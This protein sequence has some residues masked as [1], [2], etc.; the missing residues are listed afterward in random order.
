[1][2]Q[3]AAL[4]KR[5]ADSSQRLSHASAKNAKYL[6]K[7]RNRMKEAKMKNAGGAP[8]GGGH[9]RGKKGRGKAGNAA[10][11]ERRAPPRLDELD[12]SDGMDSDRENR[13]TMKKFNKLRE[14]EEGGDGGDGGDG[15]FQRNPA[16]EGRDG[17]SDGGADSSMDG[18]RFSFQT[19][20]GT[21]SPPAPTL[22]T[23][24]PLGDGSGDGGDGSGG[25]GS[26]G[27]GLPHGSPPPRDNG[28]TEEG[29]EFL[30]K[31]GFTRGMA[32]DVMR[33]KKLYPLRYVHGERG[34]HVFV[35]MCICVFVYLCVCVRR[36]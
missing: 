23:L 2:K 24:G 9:V 22:N 27:G 33:T 26:G 7:K 31:E 5:T 11:V 28:F 18:S 13:E 32:E 19:D 3:K 6:L 12:G 30:R 34:A 21:A 4:L 15:E 14:A 36:R 29:W 16:W 10:A 35:Y 8:R 1:M 25:D 17:A 20:G